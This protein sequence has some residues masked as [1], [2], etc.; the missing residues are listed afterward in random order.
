MKKTLDTLV[1]LPTLWTPK[2]IFLEKGSVDTPEAEAEKRNAALYSYAD[3]EAI[4][5]VRAYVINPF[6]QERVANA[7]TAAKKKDLF[8]K[9]SGQIK[10]PF[11]HTVP[12]ES[13]DEGIGKINFVVS[14]KRAGK[15]T[16]YAQVLDEFNSFIEEAA[17]SVVEDGRKIE[18]I[19]T[20]QGVPY[21][22]IPFLREKIKALVE[23][24]TKDPATPNSTSF[25]MLDPTTNEKKVLLASVQQMQ[26]YLNASRY[27]RFSPANAEAYYQAKSL[28]ARLSEFL[29]EVEESV[30]R[31]HAIPRTGLVKTHPRDFRFKDKSGVRYLF[32]PNVT[33]S[34]AK[35]LERLA[36]PLEGENVKSTTGDLTIIEN[37]AF[38][39]D[40]TY[41]KGKIEVRTEIG[42]Q[43]NLGKIVIERYGEKGATPTVTYHVY[44]HEQEG[45]LYV[46]VEDL[47]K[48]MG[49]IRRNSES[50]KTKPYVSFFPA[51]PDTFFKQ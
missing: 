43:R 48:N 21:I 12:F 41:P 17:G 15:S 2:E 51:V 36:T 33:V 13:D 45:I 11:V 18:G 39:E 9:R 25:E 47:S 42:E 34:Y 38:K 29:G 31:Q 7:L 4:Q 5:T 46:R 3:S 35:I 16:S 8:L 20:I 32:G 30:M 23:F 26:V 1:L 6:K 14:I 10:E 40:Y 27:K 22:E 50:N 37:L 44:K 28:E 24:Y 49:K 19:R